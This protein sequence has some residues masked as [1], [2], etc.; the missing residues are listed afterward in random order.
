MAKKKNKPTQAAVAPTLLGSVFE[1]LPIDCWGALRKGGAAC[2]VLTSLLGVRS[3]LSPP[4][5]PPAP[6]IQHWLFY[7]HFMQLL[8]LLSL[9]LL[10]HIIRASSLISLRM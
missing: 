8:D 5:P 7:N 2:P 3:H 10:R 1:L 9:P 4:M 6:V